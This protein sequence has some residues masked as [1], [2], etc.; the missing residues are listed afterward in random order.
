LTGPSHSFSAE[1]MARGPPNL[2]IFEEN[3]F[4]KNLIFEFFS[5]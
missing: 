1:A 5:K 3:L 4:K 2:K